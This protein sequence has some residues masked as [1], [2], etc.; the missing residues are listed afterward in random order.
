MA[1]APSFPNTPLLIDNDVFTRWRNQ[2]PQVVLAIKDYIKRIK[3]FPKLAAITIFETQWGVEKEIVRL[4]GQNQMMAQKR[5]EIE[6][7]I[8][9]CGVLDFNQQAASIAA[10][11]FARLSKSKRNQ[12]WKDVMTVATALAHRHGVATQNRKDFEMIGQ[13]LP[14]SASILYLAIWKS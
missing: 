2:S 6:R 7:L 10:H 4:G 5:E 14:P 9:K 12:H 11:I 13:Y 8:Q 1:T 3:S